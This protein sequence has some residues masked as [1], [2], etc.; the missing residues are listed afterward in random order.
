MK[1]FVQGQGGDKKRP[2]RDLAAF[3]YRPGVH[4]LHD[5]LEEQRAGYW[6]GGPSAR[7]RLQVLLEV[8]AS[9]FLHVSLGPPNI[10]MGLLWQ[11][12]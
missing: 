4:S 3:D 12:H 2:R 11:N 8:A 10:A 5:F 7:L 9:G 6:A 1:R